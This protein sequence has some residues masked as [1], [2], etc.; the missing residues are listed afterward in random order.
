MESG[1]SSESESEECRKSAIEEQQAE[2]LR[3]ERATLLL[4]RFKK[5]KDVIDDE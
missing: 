5:L 1:G 4:D 2:K 3:L